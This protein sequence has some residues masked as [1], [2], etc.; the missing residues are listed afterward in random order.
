MVMVMKV[1][2]R[3]IGHAPFI[4]KSFE[5]SYVFPV[6]ILVGIFPGVVRAGNDGNDGLRLVSP[7]FVFF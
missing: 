3:S 7:F 4:F 5:I 6:I 1:V 2:N